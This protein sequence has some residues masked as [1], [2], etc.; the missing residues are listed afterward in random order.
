MP[1]FLSPEDIKDFARFKGLVPDE[2]D[3]NQFTGE[4]SPRVKVQPAMTTTAAKEPSIYATTGRSAALSVIPSIASMPPSIAAGLKTS[5]YL[6][7]Q[8]WTKFHPAAAIG[9][10][11]VGGLGVGLA[12]GLGIGGATQYGQAKILEQTKS[13]ADFLAKERAGREANPISASVGDVAGSLVALK[14]NMQM[15]KDARLAL[16]TE[17]RA[18][19]GLGN[20]LLNSEAAQ[21]V[22]LSGALGGAGSVAQDLA[23]GKDVNIQKALVNT[24]LQGAVA[25]VQPWISKIPAL[26]AAAYRGQ[27]LGDVRT[28]NWVEGVERSVPLDPAVVKANDALRAEAQAKIDNEIAN[29]AAFETTAKLEMDAETDVALKA[30]KQKDD[31]DYRAL[32]VKEINAKRA[33]YNKLEKK[34]KADEDKLTTAVE[35]R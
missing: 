3:F 13:G 24:I 17:A 9:I 27:P 18:G 25:D 22:G 20:K 32:Q 29:Q 34:L 2:V 23:E 8:P 6:A 15:L 35:L 30:I 14:P 11:L 10:P 19:A 7:A 31:D 5:A 4:F 21:Q 1:T 28:V 16:T 12:T 33:E 26:K